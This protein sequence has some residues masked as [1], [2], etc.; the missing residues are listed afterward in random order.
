GLPGRVYEPRDE[1][2]LGR[3]RREQ[4]ERPRLAARDV[5]GDRRDDER[6][7]AVQPVDVAVLRVVDVAREEDLDRADERKGE[8]ESDVTPAPPPRAEGDEEGEHLGR[9]D[10]DAADVLVCVE[11]T[12]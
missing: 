8:R 4:P 7:T 5:D 6:E 9:M 2:Q 11:R 10:D 12:R 3:A 1:R